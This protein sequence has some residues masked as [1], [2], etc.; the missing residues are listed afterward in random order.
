MA[1][2]IAQE[3][4]RVRGLFFKKQ[5]QTNATQNDT[6]IDLELPDLEDLGPYLETIVA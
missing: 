5:L 6:Y 2:G 1:K 3:K 4:I